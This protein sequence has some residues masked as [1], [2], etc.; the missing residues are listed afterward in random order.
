MR[1][2][3]NDIAGGAEALSEIDFAKLCRDFDV[4]RVVRQI[5]RTDGRGRR[6]YLDGEIACKSGKRLAY[7][8]DGGI[9][10]LPELLG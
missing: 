8:V 10:L 6:R 5:M 2:A 1:L 4:G 3:I 9:H 7:E